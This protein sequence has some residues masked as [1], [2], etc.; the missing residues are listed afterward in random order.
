MTTR[1]Y[2]DCEGPTRAYLRAAGTP[3][4]ARVH[5]GTPSGVDQPGPWITMFLVN[6][7]PDPEGQLPY[8][9]ALIQFDC[10]AITKKLA[11]DLRAALTT[12][13]ESIVPGTL[14]DPTLRCWSASV[15]RAQWLPDPAND[16]P[17][18]SLDCELMVCATGA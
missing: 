9:R 13:L 12:V 2:R 1:L 8:S 3:A 6:E 4:A 14:L 7:T 15:T 5:F 17:R 18:Y 10:W 11:A 16:F